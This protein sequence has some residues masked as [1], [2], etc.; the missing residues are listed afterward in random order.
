MVDFLWTPIRAGTVK[1]VEME[2]QVLQEM[3]DFLEATVHPDAVYLFGSG[4]QGRL[5]SDSD[6]DVALLLETPLTPAEKVALSERLVDICHRPVDLIELG[7]AST[8]M[9]AQVVGKGRLLTEHHANRRAYFEMRTLKAYALLS[10]ERQV[11]LDRMKREGTL[12]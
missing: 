3:V 4:A 9:Q 5:R 2:T 7:V 1:R 6:L 10:E 8:V 12:F 11:I